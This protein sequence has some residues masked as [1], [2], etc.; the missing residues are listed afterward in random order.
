MPAGLLPAL[1]LS[2]RLPW[3]Q[4]GKEDDGRKAHSVKVRGNVAIPR[5]IQSNDSAL[6]Y[7]P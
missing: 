7:T 5:Y 1:S 6:A 2:N 3:E 4:G